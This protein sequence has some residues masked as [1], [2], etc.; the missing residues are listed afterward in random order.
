MNGEQ[1]KRQREKMVRSRATV[2]R[3][4]GISRQ[5]VASIE[6]QESVLPETAARYFSAVYGLPV[7]VATQWRIVPELVLAG[8]DT[9]PIVVASERR[10]VSA[11]SV[12]AEGERDADS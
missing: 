1:L 8:E 2:A 3:G 7:E 11:G 5:A 12:P 10:I 4:M 6:A 9:P